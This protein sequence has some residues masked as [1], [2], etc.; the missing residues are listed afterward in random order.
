MR[1][2]RYLIVCLP[3]ISFFMMNILNEKT[4]GESPDIKYQIVRSDAPEEWKCTDCH[5]ILIGMNYIHGPA[6]ESCENCHQIDQARHPESN[7]TGLYLTEEIPSLC[8]NCHEALKIEMETNRLIHH[9]MTDKKQCMNCHSPHASQEKKLLNKGE[10][11][12]CLSCHFRV[13]NT[14]E[15]NITNIKEQLTKGRVI[16]PVIE[17]DGCVIC[18][19]PHTSRFNYLLTKSYPAGE[20][21]P[22]KIENFELCWE[23]H[24]SNLLNVAK[25]KTSTNFRNGDNN[26]HFIHMNGEKARNC[27]MCHNVHASLNE[28]LIA[29]KVSFGN[30]ELPLNYIANENGGSCF[31]GCHAKSEY[32]R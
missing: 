26:L 6:G 11:D 32:S 10:I 22:A 2:S 21:A 18:H 9:A 19:L 7:A 29:E 28:H 3:F 16:H 24:D 31:P 15:R 5:E 1:I 20:Y 17:S 13:I 12:V 8:F 30:W 25:T 27:S 4:G 14:N 23:C